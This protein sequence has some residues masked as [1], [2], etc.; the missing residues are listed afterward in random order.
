MVKKRGGTLIIQ[1]RPA[2]LN[3]F[4]QLNCVDEF[5]SEPENHKAPDIQFD[6]HTSPLELP[7][8]FKTTLDN[9][10]CDIPYLNAD[11]DKIEYWET[12]SQR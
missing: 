3:L 2:M 12:Q 9:I 4:K 5:I 8:I 6:Y 1:A 11:P 10:P 7:R